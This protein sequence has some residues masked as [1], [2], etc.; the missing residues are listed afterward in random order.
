VG[1]TWLMFQLYSCGCCGKA[2]DLCPL[3]GKRK[4]IDIYIYI[5]IYV[6]RLHSIAGNEY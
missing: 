6:I 3:N 5:Y 1:K 4:N 2:I